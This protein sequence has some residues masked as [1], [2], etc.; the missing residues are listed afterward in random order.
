MA[1]T[2]RRSVPLKNMCSR[3]WEIPIQRSG[4][5]KNPALT[6]VT[7][8]TTG[9]ERSSWTSSVSPLGRTWRRTP[10][11]QS[12]GA[13]D[14]MGCLHHDSQ[15]AGF[16]ATTNEGLRVGGGNDDAGLGLPPPSQARHEVS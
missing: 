3:T 4:S 9:A 5:S 11:V 1:P 8:A 7:T 6:W 12:G 13:E 15:H 10:A 16:G 14:T 2:P